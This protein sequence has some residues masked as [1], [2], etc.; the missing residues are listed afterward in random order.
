[1]AGHSLG[2]LG[3]S[4]VDHLSEDLARLLK[5]YNTSYTFSSWARWCPPALFHF[6]DKHCVSEC[7][8]VSRASLSATGTDGT[9]S[10][11][12]Q[13]WSGPS[14][15]QM[16]R[17]QEVEGASCRAEGMGRVKGSRR[18]LQSSQEGVVAPPGP[19]GCE[20]GGLMEPSENWTCQREPLAGAGASDLSVPCL[21]DARWASCCP[22]PT[23]KPT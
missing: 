4:L 2:F 21:R 20:L 14:R 10:K 3:Q 13:N 6:R 7:F 18:G 12:H 15:E 1:M 17:A 23:R 11:G 9:P 19:E 5:V 16:A 8:G 22:D